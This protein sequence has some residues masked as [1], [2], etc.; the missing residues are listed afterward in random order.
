M[1]KIVYPTVVFHQSQ[2]I[3]LFWYKTIN[4]FKSTKANVL[5]KNVDI[6][7]CNFLK[8]LTNSNQSHYSFSQNMFSKKLDQR[9]NIIEKN[10]MPCFYSFKYNL[11]IF[12]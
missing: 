8:F 6:G 11:Y 7:N 5:S 1:N 12:A 4:P 9:S 3:N 2:V 10:I